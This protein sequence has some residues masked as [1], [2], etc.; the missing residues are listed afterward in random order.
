V[1]QSE[2]SQGKTVHASKRVSAESAGF[3]FDRQWVVVREADGKFITQRQVAWK[4]ADTMIN[5]RT[6]QY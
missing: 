4:L 6:V 5:Q 2:T 3:A 1:P